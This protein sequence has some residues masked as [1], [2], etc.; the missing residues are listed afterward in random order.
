MNSRIDAV[1]VVVPAHDEQTLLPACL[2]S[3]A[4]S[5]DLLRAEGGAVRTCVCVVA[6]RCS[7]ATEDRALTFADRFDRFSVLTGTTS[8]RLGEVRN[9]G[10]AH[11][12]DVLQPS[13]LDRTW[14]LHTDADTTVPPWWVVQHVRYAQRGVHAVA[15]R[16]VIRHW[17][18]PA[19]RA[20][21][22]YEALVA[23]RVAADHHRHVYGA[24]LGVRADAFA[25]A[26]GFPPVATGEDHGLW[27]RLVRAGRVTRQPNEH[28]VLTSGRTV[29]RAAGGLAAL[30]HEL[31]TPAERPT[32]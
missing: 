20:R 11:A 12:F 15:G 19:L 23:D 28:P 5:L 13:A 18:G 32:G 9:R 14:L 27:A 24:N 31:S 3:L 2:H 22:R 26:G 30:L 25:A 6:D 29:G 4:R 17:S 16:A 7:D 10:T 1:T 21:S 8:Y